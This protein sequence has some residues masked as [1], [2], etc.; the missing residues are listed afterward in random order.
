M[1][2]ITCVKQ[3]CTCQKRPFYRY[4]KQFLNSYDKWWP[5]AGMF[6]SC[7][8]VGAERGSYT[9]KSSRLLAFL[10]LHPF[11]YH[12][13]CIP[14]WERQGSGSQAAVQQTL[15]ALMPFS[16]DYDSVPVRTPL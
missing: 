1:K 16:R 8:V 11:W 6:K 4:W 12:H 3:Y 7:V 15:T 5:I 14:L 10:A 2:S 13:R 9:R